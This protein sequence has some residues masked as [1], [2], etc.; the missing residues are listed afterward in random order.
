MKAWIV[1]NWDKDWKEIVFADNYREA[2]KKATHTSLCENSDDFINLRV[3]RYPDMDD[4]ENLNH[5]ECTYKLWQSGCVWLDTQTLGPYNE[6]DDER[7]ARID[8][9]SWYSWYY[10]G[11]ESNEIN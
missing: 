2:N 9:L 4:T 1:E 6:Y 10:K 7:I 5:K 8:F 3:K 11:S